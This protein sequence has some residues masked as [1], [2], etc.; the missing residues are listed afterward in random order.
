M[1]TVRMAGLCAMR[2]IPR[3]GGF[4]YE[5]VRF[6]YLLVPKNH[7]LAYMHEGGDTARYRAS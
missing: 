5:Q 2:S 6:P 3:A 1:V 4:W 7:L